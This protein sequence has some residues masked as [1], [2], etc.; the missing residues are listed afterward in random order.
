MT[1]PDY[2][3][4]RTCNR[5]VRKGHVDTNGDCSTHAKPVFYGPKPTQP[6]PDAPVEPKDK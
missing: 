3:T 1:H 4:C 5:I 6:E 2:V